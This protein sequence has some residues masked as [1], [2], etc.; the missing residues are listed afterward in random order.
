MYNMHIHSRCLQLYSDFKGI[1]A[2][3]SGVIDGPTAAPHRN[4]FL[5]AVQELREQL[6]LQHQVVSCSGRVGQME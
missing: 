5:G 4:H 2:L 6:P 1:E 3:Q